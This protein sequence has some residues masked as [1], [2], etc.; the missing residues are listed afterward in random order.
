MLICREQLTQFHHTF[1][2]YQYKEHF[3]TYASV[4]G[5]HTIFLKNVG[6]VGGFYTAYYTLSL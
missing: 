3:H 1:I 6:C 2:K 5:F 4:C